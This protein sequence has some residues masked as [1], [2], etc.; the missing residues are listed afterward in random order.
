[1]LAALLLPFDVGVRRITVNLRRQLGGRP[2][3]VNQSLAAGHIGS[4][5]QAKARAGKP[6]ER[7]T[8]PSQPR[9]TA[10]SASSTAS[11]L[12]KRRRQR[13]EEQRG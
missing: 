6:S 12:L 3:P 13:A 10:Q 7:S 2:M 9:P 4:L 8:Q 11:E 5:L 1:M